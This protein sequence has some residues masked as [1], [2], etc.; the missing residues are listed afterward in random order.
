MLT[1]CPDPRRGHGCREL[2]WRA[3]RPL[4]SVVR[5][6]WGLTVLDSLSGRLSEDGVG[7]NALD[8]RVGQPD[9]FTPAGGVGYNACQAFAVGMAF[10]CF[11]TAQGVADLT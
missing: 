2:V 6:L 1:V 11:L 5:L 7:R 10:A 8:V 9:P 4:T 3:S